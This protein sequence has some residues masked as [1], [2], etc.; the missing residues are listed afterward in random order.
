[1]KKP[2]LWDG[3]P[4]ESLVLYGD[5]MPTWERLLPMLKPMF[6]WVD[7]SL[8]MIRWQMPDRVARLAGISQDSTC[9][10]PGCN[11]GKMLAYSEDGESGFLI[12]TNWRQ[13]GWF[14][15]G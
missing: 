15:D 8:V 5:H 14:F 4:A 11:C 7:E 6:T 10:N 13:T 2:P 1:M 3:K 12:D 9:Q